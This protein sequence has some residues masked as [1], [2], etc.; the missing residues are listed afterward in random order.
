MA[1][2]RQSRPLFLPAI[3]GVVLFGG[4]ACM[5]AESS[6]NEVF[7][8]LRTRALVKAACDGKAQRVT[9]LVA[10]G[11]DPN[12]SGRRGMPPLLWVIDRCAPPA[13]EHLLNA[14]AN[15]NSSYVVRSISCPVIWF[16]VRKSTPAYVKLLLAHGASPDAVCEGGGSD[17]LTEAFRVGV[18]TGSWESYYALL[19][20]G[21]DIN[22]EHLGNTVGITS[23][24]LGRYDKLRELLR[25]GYNRDLSFVASI[26]Y[27]N[28]EVDEER[29]IE[30]SEVL[31]LLSEMGYEPDSGANNVQ[32][33]AS[34]TVDSH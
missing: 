34:N 12:A 9:E 27:R 19:E 6:L 31:R 24:A 15:P 29:I 10:T 14:G 3:V 26:V 22:K 11:V 23:A 8:D 5:S 32:P 33:T 21:A 28:G 17:A 20:A 13:A 1:E 18:K 25:L 16:A 30:R 2:G 7:S 4:V